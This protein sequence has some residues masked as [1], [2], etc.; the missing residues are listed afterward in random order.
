MT[1]IPNN[2]IASM[3]LNLFR[4]LTKIRSNEMTK[5]VNIH[6][7]EASVK[8]NEIVIKINY[9]PIRFEPSPNG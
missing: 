7:F 3:P 5:T 4:I 8:S 2:I 6:Q 9:E 1:K